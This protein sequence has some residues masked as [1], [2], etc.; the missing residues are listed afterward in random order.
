M[1]AMFKE[2]LGFLRQALG[3][4][5]YL[6]AFTS[7]MFLL[8]TSII[9]QIVLV[10]LY[11]SHLSTYQFGILMMLLSFVNFAVIGI[12]WMS[13]GSLRLLGEYAGLGRD[14][15]FRRAFGL[16]QLI[17]AG[18]GV[19]LAVIIALAAI[20]LPSLFWREATQIDMDAV[21]HAMIVTGVYMIAFI[22]SRRSIALH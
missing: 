7:S 2:M 9:L 15:D 21:R 20:L 5:A 12:A 13:G 19:V 8:A 10:P 16:I 3:H 6:G 14:D 4:R 17:Y 22:T 1:I 18:Y 11:L